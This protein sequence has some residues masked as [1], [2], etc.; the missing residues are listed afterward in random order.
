MATATKDKADDA[1]K[2]EEKKSF[3]KSK[4]AIIGLVALLAVGGG[5]YKFMAPAKATP[6]TG[7]DIVALDATTLNLKGGHYLKLAVAIQVVQGKATADDFKTSEA[8][9]LVIDEFSDRTVASLSSSEDRKKLVEDL[10]KKIKKAYEGE[11]FDV[12]LTQFVTQ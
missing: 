12:F 10:E 4:K 3:L 5:A 11:V 6:V 9:E 7:G 1:E 2:K 8:Q